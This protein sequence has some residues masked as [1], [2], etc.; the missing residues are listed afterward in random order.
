MKIKILILSL[1]A[2][3]TFAQKPA[4]KDYLL[5]ISTDFGEINMILYDEAPL[6]KANF[7]NLVKKKFYKDLLFHR[8]IENFMIQGGDPNSRNA[9]P[10]TNLGDGGDE[11]ERIPFEFKSN[12]IHKKGTLA[13]ARDGNPEKKS[14]ACQFYIDVTH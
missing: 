6:H 12:R 10:E 4:K 11:L 8:I 9:K 3:S 1:L 2:F 5:S 7:L 13:A 14:S